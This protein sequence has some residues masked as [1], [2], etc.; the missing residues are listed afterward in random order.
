MNT[1][2][3]VEGNDVWLVARVLRPDNVPVSQA[4]LASGS[5]AVEVHVY[6]IT[7][8]SLGTGANGRQVL[9]K[10]IA[11][12]SAGS[13]VVIATGSDPL[14]T[15][16]YWNGYDDTGYNFIYQ[17]EVSDSSGGLEGVDHVALQAG[18]RYQ[19]EFTI[20]TGANAFGNIKWAQQ[21]YIRSLLSV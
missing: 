21:L 5:D 15:D 2:E 7:T 20:R 17:I 6:D 4:D 14:V 18:R 3:V 13:I 8:S 9:N 1:Q 19:V 11:Q 16:G 12:G 10:T